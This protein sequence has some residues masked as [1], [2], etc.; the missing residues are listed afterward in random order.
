MFLGIADDANMSTPNYQVARLRRAH[1]CEI[2]A[3]NP[4]VEF[5]RT[6]VVV[7]KTALFVDVMN[8]V[9]T[10]RFR[11]GISV[12]RGNGS[13]NLATLYLVD[14]ARFERMRKG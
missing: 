7:G 12:Y 10:V 5:V 2:R 9:G 13:Q 3:R 4:D 6:G 14:W 11:V 8:Q 1:T